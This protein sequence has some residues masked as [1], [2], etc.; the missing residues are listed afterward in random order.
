MSGASGID[1]RAASTALEDGFSKNELGIATVTRIGVEML[2]AIGIETVPLIV[3]PDGRI[4]Y[5]AQ[6]PRY[7]F[8]IEPRN[9]YYGR[10]GRSE[11]IA[12]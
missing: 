1:G 8:R 12:E 6:E 9:E 4:G 7:V 11:K 5:D 3:Y 2:A 10:W